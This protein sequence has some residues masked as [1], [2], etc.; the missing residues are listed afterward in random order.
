MEDKEEKKWCV[1]IHTCKEN[2]KKY[3]GQTMNLKNRWG[4]NGAKYLYK[5]KDGTWRQ[6]A[7]ARAIL[8]HG[9]DGFLHEVVADNLNSNLSKISDRCFVILY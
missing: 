4:N 8:A 5:Q 3:I 6:P 1:Y 9:W 2:N 7:M